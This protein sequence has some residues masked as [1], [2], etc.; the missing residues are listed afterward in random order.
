MYNKFF[1]RL[2]ACIFSV[3]IIGA[4]IM[5]YTAYAEEN[6]V[7]SISTSFIMSPMYEKIS[8]NPGDSYSSSFM[9]VTPSQ[10]TS[11]FDYKVYVQGYYRDDNN[12]TIFENIGGHSQIVDWVQI[13][14][15]KTGTLKPDD[16]AKISFTINVPKDAPAG[17]QYAVITVGSATPEKAGEGGGVNIQESVAMGYTIYAEITGT[18][19]KQGE[20]T[21]ASVPGF[22]FSGNITGSSSVKNTGN[23]HGDAKYTLQVFPLFSDEEVYTNSENP[24][25][26]VVLPDRTLYNETSWNNTPWFGIFNVV[27]TV[28]F[29]GL[30]SQVSKIVIIC[31]VW[32]LFIIIFIIIALIIWFILRFENHKKTTCGKPSNNEA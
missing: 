31:P 8:L 11:N 23:V 30:S 17:G 13:N 3:S 9:I 7:K 24:E 15:P 27:Y 12:N 1:K 21:G 26:R 10:A 32:L 28:D 2:F 4:S 6:A 16:S 20:V 14:S 19:I 5:P 25:T 22:I 18:T 29:N